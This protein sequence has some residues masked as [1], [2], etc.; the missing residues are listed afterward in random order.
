MYIHGV[1]FKVWGF[2]S[3]VLVL[4]FEGLISTVLVLRFVGLFMGLGVWG[5]G[6]TCVM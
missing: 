4:R 1:G 3:T 5:L 6:V 2:I